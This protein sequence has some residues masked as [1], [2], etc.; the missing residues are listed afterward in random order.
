MARAYAEEAFEVGPI[1]ARFEAIIET[2]VRG[3]G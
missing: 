2:A 3:V 1:A